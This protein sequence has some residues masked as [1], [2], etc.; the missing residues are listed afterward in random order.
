MKFCGGVRGGTK[1]KWLDFVSNPDHDLALVEVCA[2][3]EYLENDD[4]L[5]IW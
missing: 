1:N 5:D 3:L 2:L 4:C